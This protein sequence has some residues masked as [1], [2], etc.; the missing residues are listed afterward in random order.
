MNVQFLPDHWGNVIAVQL[1]I[2]DWKKLER[3]V[4]AYDLAASIQIGL[5]ETELIEKGE[6]KLKSLEDLLNEI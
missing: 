2:K 5:K 6:I 3:K 4:K 1:L